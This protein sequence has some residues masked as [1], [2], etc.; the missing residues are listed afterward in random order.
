[1]FLSNLRQCMQYRTGGHKSLLYVALH[2]EN[3]TTFDTFTCDITAF[4]DITLI[5]WIKIGIS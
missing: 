3:K 1:M 2:C 4:E 5:H